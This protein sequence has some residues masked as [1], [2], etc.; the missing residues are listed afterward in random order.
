MTTEE[1]T[2]YQQ[3][4]TPV[5]QYYH[6]LGNNIEPGV[7]ELCH[8]TFMGSFINILKESH[9]EFWASRFDSQNDPLEF[10]YAEKYT[11][12]HLGIKQ[13]NV[14]NCYPYMISFSK[15]RDDLNMWRLYKS[16]VCLV[17]D[18][19]KA[20]KPYIEIEKKAT[21][22]QDILAGSVKYYKDKDDCDLAAKYEEL[23]SNLLCLDASYADDKCEVLSQ[24]AMGLLKPDTFKVEN[25]Y[26]IIMPDYSDFSIQSS[27]DNNELTVTE[28]EKTVGIE[29]RIRNDDILQY[30]PMKFPKDALCGVIINECDTNRFMLKKQHVLN[31][32]RSRGYDL[33]EASIVQT[34]HHFRNIH[35]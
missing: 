31:L 7:Q 15:E 12:Q 11:F 18:I 19:N 32:L 8:Y 22:L 33:P 34:N 26:R 5:N 35:Y 24:Y 1:Y 28:K 29:F 10:T 13:D 27:Q 20:M 21:C 6:L 23:K 25:E 16:E 2:F 4:V 14:V 30:K 17:I 9:I 3:V